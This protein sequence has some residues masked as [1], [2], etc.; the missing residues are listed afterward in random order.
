MNPL[1]KIPVR[2]VLVIVLALAALAA[3]TLARTT[4]S[5]VR[6]TEME[7]PMK[8][9]TLLASDHHSTPA[10]IPPIDTLQPV[11][12]ATASFGLG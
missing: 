2:G 9:S 8:A 1:T 4:A 5:E 7:R 6:Q 10:P 3:I 12:V 11:A